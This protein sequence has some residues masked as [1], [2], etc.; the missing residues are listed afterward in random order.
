MVCM[1]IFM[2]MDQQNCMMG[3]S[4]IWVLLRLLATEEKASIRKV[5]SSVSKISVKERG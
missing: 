2:N 1:I 5:P 3:L 4:T